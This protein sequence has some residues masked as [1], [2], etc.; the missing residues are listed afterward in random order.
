MFDPS[1]N[2]IPMDSERVKVLRNRFMLDDLVFTAMQGYRDG[3]FMVHHNYPI[4]SVTTSQLE[5]MLNYE[6]EDEVSAYLAGWRYWLVH[7]SS[8]FNMEYDRQPEWWPMYMGDH[9]Q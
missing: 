2:P 6:T 5:G 7:E 1:D 4:G 3:M 8:L 9:S